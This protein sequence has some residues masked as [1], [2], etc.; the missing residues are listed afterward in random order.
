MINSRSAAG[1]GKGGHYRAWLKPGDS[2][3]RKWRGGLSPGL[4]ICVGLAG[5]HAR[6]LERV[7]AQPGHCD[8]AGREADELIEG[9]HG[10]EVRTLARRCQAGA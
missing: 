3:L 8:P 4:N 1:P 5:G 7:R 10:P 2:V 9:D 6:Q